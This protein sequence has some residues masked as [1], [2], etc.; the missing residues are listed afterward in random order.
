MESNHYAE[1]SLA[2]ETLRKEGCRRTG[3]FYMENNRA[4]NQGRRLGA[5]L[6][7]SQDVPPRNRLPPLVVTNAEDLRPVEAWLR[8]HKPDAVISERG[9]MMLCLRRKEPEIRWVS[10][11]VEN[12]ESLEG[13]FP[14]RHAVGAG[15]VDM[16]VAQLH[17]GERGPPTLPKAV[18]IVGRWVGRD[19]LRG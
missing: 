6:N 14:A 11:T 4:S 17:R 1:M 19:Q 15:A 2:C 18:Q 10:L 12:L 7:A 16:V 9:D 3:Y 5:Y 8:R 13:I